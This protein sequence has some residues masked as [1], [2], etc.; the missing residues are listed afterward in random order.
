[1]PTWKIGPGANETMPGDTTYAY[2]VI[3]AEHSDRPA[4]GLERTGVLRLTRDLPVHEVAVQI[5]AEIRTKA[6]WPHALI[7]R[8]SI[9]NV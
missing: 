4:I 9:W 3:A 7:I 6:G 2:S 8:G 1:M 5:L